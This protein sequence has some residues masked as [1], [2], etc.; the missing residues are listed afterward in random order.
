MS[1]NFYKRLSYSFGNEDSKTEQEALQISPNARVV[2]ITASGDRPLNLLTNDCAELVCV[3]LNKTQNFLLNLKVAA[4]QAFDYSNYLKFLGI[5]E[6]NNRHHSYTSLV[7]FLD[8]ETQ[9]FW[10]SKQKLIKKG[11]IYQGAL[12]R[13]AKKISK[14]IRF[15]RKS[16][17]EKLFS[18]NDLEE[19]KKFL[20]EEWN[21]WI[22]RKVFDLDLY[23]T[24]SRFFLKDPAL[25][26]S[27][28]PSIKIGPYIYDR[29]SWSLESRLAKLNP[30]LSLFIKGKILPEA[31]P[32]YLTENGINLIKS[33]V[34]KLNIQT[35][36]IVDYLKSCPDN[37][38]DAFSMSDVASYLDK[39]T[40]EELLKAILRTAKPNA[41][42]S[43]RQFLSC[44]SIPLTLQKHFQRELDLEKRLKEEDFCFIYNFTV[45]KISK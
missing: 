31:F 5:A 18:F 7:P 16:K 41:R 45:G 15:F 34:N 36:D 27:V 30:F 42:F 10:N 1:K 9:S 13:W 39:N 21:N 37:H 35:M 33:R 6:C 2:C 12:E 24:I 44:H 43:I 28:N 38:F 8:A 22:W 4:I 20:K 40:F 17:V 11:V 19:Q 29:I 25:S 23:P 26:F 14:T 32:P 3:D